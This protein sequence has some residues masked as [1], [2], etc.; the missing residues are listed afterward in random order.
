MDKADTVVKAAEQAEGLW[1]FVERIVGSGQVASAVL[2]LMAVAFLIAIVLV[3][4][5]VRKMNP[6]KTQETMIRILNEQ[7]NENARRLTEQQQQHISHIREITEQNA[8]LHKQMTTRQTEVI[9]QNSIDFAR[10]D[11]SNKQMTAAM[12]GFREFLKEDF[13]GTLR[14]HIEEAVEEG[15]KKAATTRKRTA[16]RSTSSSSRKKKDAA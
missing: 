12:V 15:V 2:L 16:S 8:E 9:Q 13:P 11:E 3:V 10:V 14:S 6:V 4:L 7:S 5:T 1:G